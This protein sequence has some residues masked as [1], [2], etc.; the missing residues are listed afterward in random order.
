MPFPSLYSLEVQ[1]VQEK[2]HL[3]ERGKEELSLG[4]VKLMVPVLCPS[5]CVHFDLRKRFR[6]VV[7]IG[8]QV[9]VDAVEAGLMLSCDALAWLCQMLMARICFYLSMPTFASY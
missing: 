8:E 9:T 7:Q 6:V 2:T 1:T 5:E 4:N 3:E